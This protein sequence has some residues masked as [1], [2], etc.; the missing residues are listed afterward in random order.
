MPPN[1]PGT[2]KFSLGPWLSVP[3]Q[4][5]YLACPS[6]LM[7]CRRGH[8]LFKYY[9]LFGQRGTSPASRAVDNFN[10]QQGRGVKTSTDWG[11]KSTAH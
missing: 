6:A 9:K 5:P 8:V 1:D 10:Y 3:L 7:W 2:P 11:L 4:T